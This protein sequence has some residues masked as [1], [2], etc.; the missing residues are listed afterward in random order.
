MRWKAEAHKIYEERV[1]ND[2]L[3]RLA[4]R[5]DL[6]GLPFS[7][8]ELKTL[9]KRS[10]ESFRNPKTGRERLDRYKAHLAKIYGADQVA[11]ISGSLEAINNAIG[12][13]EK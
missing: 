3:A 12:Y 7:D 8:D 2:A 4:E 10:R 6:K 1:V 5:L 9:A 11:S 13:E